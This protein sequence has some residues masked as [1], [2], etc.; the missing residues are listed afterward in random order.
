MPN[1]NKNFE[2][3]VNPTSDFLFTDDLLKNDL[4]IKAVYD[5][6]FTELTKFVE[7]MKGIT[8]QV[9]RLRKKP[10]TIDYL[11]KIHC[12][13]K[14]YTYVINI[15]FHRE[16]IEVSVNGKSL[17]ESIIFGANINKETLTPSKIKADIA[18]FK[19]GLSEFIN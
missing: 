10:K 8:I 18:F 5:K 2:K 7:K 9:C 4:Y 11:G 15:V 6:V 13:T 12:R 17:G 3:I 19:K 1:I 14:K 16:V